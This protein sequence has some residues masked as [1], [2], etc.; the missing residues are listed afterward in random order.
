M[1]SSALKQAEADRDAATADLAEAEG[2]AA[3]AERAAAEA[4]FPPDGSADPARCR[5]LTRTPRS[6]PSSAS[7]SGRCR[8]RR[9][10]ASC[11]TDSEP[12]ALGKTSIWRY[13]R[14]LDRERRGG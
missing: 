5:A 4:I 7:G 8:W 13:W 1:A 3:E 6:A 14:R 10:R 2:R 11:G 9:S 12:T